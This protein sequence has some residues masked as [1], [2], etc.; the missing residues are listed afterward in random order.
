MTIPQDVGIGQVDRKN[1]VV[2]ADRGTEKKRAAPAEQQLEAR[3]ESGSRMIK[4]EVSILETNHVPMQIEHSERVPMLEHAS[5]RTA[6]L[7]VRNNREMFFKADDF[8][9]GARV[10]TT[11]PELVATS[12]RYS[13]T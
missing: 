1:R 12:C 3:Q 7:G 10:Y 4:P 2:F 13:S 6:A 9:H 5:R 8:G 11:N